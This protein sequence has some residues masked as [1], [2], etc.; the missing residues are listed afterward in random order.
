MNPLKAAN[1]VSLT[2]R[3]AGVAGTAVGLAGSLARVAVQAPVGI[4]RTQGKI[5][6]SDGRRTLSADDIITIC[7][8]RRIVGRRVNL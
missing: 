1:H 2:H 5:H 8:G 6:A 4:A 7:P 3:A